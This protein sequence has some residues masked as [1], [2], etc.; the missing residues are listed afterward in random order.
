MTTTRSCIVST[1]PTRGC[2]S[3]RKG[4]TVRLAASLVALNLAACCAATQDRATDVGTPPVVPREHPRLYLRAPQAAQLPTRLKDPV[5]RPVVERLQ[6][7]AKRSPQFKV[8][9]DALQSLATKN[10]ALGRAT[11]EATLPL[12]RHCELPDRKDACRVTGRMMVTGAI[13]YD[14]LYEWMSAEEKQAFIKELVRLARTQ[15]CGYPPTR[16]GSVTGHASEAMILRD[17]LS[18]GIAIH[19]EFPEMYRLAA[20]RFFREHLPARNWFYHGHAHH[21]GAS[22]G[23]YRFGW[24]TFPLFIFDRLGCGNIYNP[25]QRFVPYLWVYST[26]PDGQRLRAGDT[27]LEGRP[28]PW[29]ESVGTLLTAS[30]YRDG[31]LLSQ[32][33]RQGG[34][35]DTESLFEFL[36]RDT[37]LQPRSIESLPLARYF[38]SPFGWMIARTG[39]DKDAVIAEMK[40]N[41]YNFANHQH[42]DAGAFQL[43]YRGA[44]AIDS[45]LYH[46]SS[47]EYGSPHCRNYFWRTVAHNSLLVYDP[48]EEFGRDYGNDGGQRLPNGRREPRTLEVLLAPENGYRTGQVFARA[49]GPDFAYLQGDITA[50][51]SKKVRNVVRSFLFLNLQNARTPAVLIVF[52]RVVSA[53][54]SFKKFWLLHT[55]VEPQVRGA[56]ASADRLALDVLLPKP[57]NVALEKV[58]GSGKEFW[59]FGVN[60]ANEP[61]GRSARR[62]NAGGS[63]V[64]SGRWRLEVSPQKEAAE[65]LFLTVMQLGERLPVR[66]VEAGERVGC[67]IGN[68]SVLFYRDGRRTDVPAL[69]WVRVQPN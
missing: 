39:W 61:E 67:Q 45:G 40:I 37:T 52:D 33:L 43:Y 51:Y 30:Y 11:I 49:I 56:S 1:W 59:V 41:E 34:V 46:G 66:L 25:Q 10:R 36:W 9:W 8:E 42:L 5:L 24:E 2:V 58:G 47:G 63:G 57:E 18:A 27:G 26:R 35:A 64:E 69:S 19:D 16:G 20:G 48:K 6:T 32:F 15:E 22:Y 55:L 68:R 31:V 21:Q 38:G 4:W 12:L 29:G 23:P 60:Y 53:E 17:M 62:G 7:L 54:P 65:D 3:P 14:W 44:Q 13:V 28:G 50:A